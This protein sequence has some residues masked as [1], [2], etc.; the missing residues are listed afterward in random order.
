MNLYTAI[1]KRLFIAILAVTMVMVLFFWQGRTGFSLWDEGFLWYGVQRVLAG[2]VPVRDFMAYDPGRY[3]WSAALM[4]LGGDHGIVALRLTLVAVQVL[5]LVI[6]VQLLAGTETRPK[7]LWW[8]LVASTLLVWMIPRHKLYDV[9]VSLALIGALTHWIRQTSLLR[10]GLAGV[11]VGL[12]AVVGQNHGVYGVLGSLGVMVYLA[13]RRNSGPGLVAGAAAWCGGVVLG[14]LPVLLML[15]VVP[16][17]AASFWDGIRFL[18]ESGTTNLPLPVPWPWHM[19]YGNLPFLKGLQGMLLGLFFIAVGGFPIVAMFWVFRA[20]LRSQAL[21]PALVAS[22][23]LALPYAHFAYSRADLSHLAQG[24]FPFLIGAWAW[25]GT[26]HALRKWGIAALL[27]ATSL[28]LL[29]PHLPGWQCRAGQSCVETAVAG[30]SIRMDPYT[31]KDVR[32]LQQLAIN[33]APGDRSIVVTP[34]WPGAYALLKR[35][36]PMWEIYALFPRSEAFQRLEIA[37]ITAADPGF[38]LI[39][40]QPLDQREALR[41]RNTH[42]LI[43]RYIRDHY[44]PLE[45]ISNNPAYHVYVG[46]RPSG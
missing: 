26:Q 35:R 2:E 8:L 40:D 29:I 13:V 41:F 46:S 3:Y 36:S 10:Y 42:P 15:L 1:H 24:I 16:G 17:F 37:R 18:F 31:A 45:N 27:C 28:L 39:I 33:Y 43:D 19:P 11:V 25:I 38:I 22:A 5:G 44:R 34:F 21:P 12:S 7:A 14:Y 20:R 6:G 23:F 32:L 30:E 9:T 4:A